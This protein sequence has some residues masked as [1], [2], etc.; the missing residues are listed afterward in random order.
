MNLAC[1]NP[2]ESLVFPVSSLFSGVLSSPCLI[3]KAR[4]NS[5]SWLFP[6]LFL[7]SQMFQTHSLH[8]ASLL[9]GSQAW[10]RCESLFQ[11]SSLHA[12][13]AGSVILLNLPV[14]Q[15]ALFRSHTS[16][17]HAAPS[18]SSTAQQ[19]HT[20]EPT[21][22]PWPRQPLVGGLGAGPSEQRVERER[23]GAQAGASRDART[24]T[25]LSRGRCG[26][27]QGPFRFLCRF[28]GVSLSG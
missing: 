27:T 2:L 1:S 9:Q 22:G 12:L 23:A 14:E 18:D 20:A 13:A 8:L 3:L 15:S 11:H 28:P 7:G 17:V 5:P 10:L 26:W 25:S 6:S 4:L 19:P 21:A 24:S 16:S